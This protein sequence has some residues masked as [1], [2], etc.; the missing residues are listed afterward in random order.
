MPMAW[1]NPLSGEMAV[2][3]VVLQSLHALSH[4]QFSHKAMS[5]SMADFGVMG[6][7]GRTGRQG[8][9]S[10]A[11]AGNSSL[12]STYNQAKMLSQCM[13]LVGLM[14]PAGSGLYATTPLLSALMRVENRQVRFW[15]LFIRSANNPCPH[16]QKAA[17]SQLRPLLTGL[18]MMKDLGGSIHRDEFLIGILTILEDDLDPSQYRAS[19]EEIRALRR[20]GTKKNLNRLVTEMR[21]R[22]KD[23]EFSKTQSLSSNNNYRNWTRIPQAAGLNA[24]LTEQSSDQTI[25][26]DGRDGESTRTF[27]VEAKEQIESLLQRRDIRSRETDRMPPAVRHAFL[28]AAHRNLMLEWG[29]ETARDDQDIQRIRAYDAPL[30]ELLLEDAVLHHPFA[31]QPVD[32]LVAAGLM[33]EPSTWSPSRL[34]DEKYPDLIDIPRLILAD[35]DNPKTVVPKRRHERPDLY[36]RG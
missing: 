24:G 9:A 28:R 32:T 20:V 22:L 10:S 35:I 8:L 27:R 12:N 6:G 15:E 17:P 31:E 30:A 13:R 4:T 33:Q 29:L 19:L 23:G 1:R 18:R 2:W 25:G 11:Q 16:V 5:F 7:K 14:V 36:R 21:R 26:Y 3:D 34:N